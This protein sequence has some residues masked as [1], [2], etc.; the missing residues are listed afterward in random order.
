VR[1]TRDLH[2]E[3]Q[4]AFLRLRQLAEAGEGEARRKEGLRRLKLLFTARERRLLGPKQAEVKL[5]QL[6]YGMG[7]RIS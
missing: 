5:P 6:P 7:N 2:G 3:D 4:G 1:G